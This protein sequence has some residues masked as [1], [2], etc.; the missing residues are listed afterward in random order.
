MSIVPGNGAPAQ[1]LPEHD[2]VLQ[3]PAAPKHRAPSLGAANSEQ[4]VEF[5]DTSQKDLAD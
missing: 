5:V 1:L 4:R 2:S 3:V